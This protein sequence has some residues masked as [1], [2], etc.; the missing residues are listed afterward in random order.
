MDDSNLDEVLTVAQRIKRG[1]IMRMKSKMIQRKRAFSM[2]KRASA[3]KL[4]R[5]ARKKARN[6]IARKY[7][8]GKSKDEMG[9]GELEY[10][11]KKLS[12]KKAI[13]KKIAKR[14]L[15][16]VR[17]AETVRLAKLRSKPKK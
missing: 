6:F 8:G 7:M 1:R 17:K 4:E 9:Y 3:E 14:L 12:L 15:P 2:K 11:E 10:L 5:R 13:I 16:Q